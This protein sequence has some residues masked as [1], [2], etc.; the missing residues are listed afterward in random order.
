[1]AAWAAAIPLAVG[2]L[3]YLSGQG[4]NEANKGIANAQMAFQER[5]S[6]TS[7]QRAVKDMSAAGLNPMLAYS[8][9][10]ASTPSGATATMTNPVSS[11]VHSGVNAYQKQ[12]EVKL[13]NEQAEKVKADADVSRINAALI[14]EQIPLVRAQVHQSTSSAGHLNQQV[15]ESRQRVENLRA[16]WHNIPLHGD[17]IRATI[18]EIRARIPVHKVTPEKIREEIRN[19]VA[20][21]FNK[22]LTSDQLTALSE[23]VRAETRL[24]NLQYSIHEAGALP[25]AQAMGLKWKSSW[26]QDVSPYLSDLSTITNSAASLRNIGRGMGFR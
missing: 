4:T 18:D 2:A 26:G 3:D 22:R 10:G 25:E 16:E 1:M 12:A 23:N 19:L 7:Y 13:I 24:K 17:Q 9:G 5:M 14:A 11:A 20:E 6:N 8:Q 15:E 21:R